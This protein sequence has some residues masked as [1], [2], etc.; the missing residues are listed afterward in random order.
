MPDNSILR[1]TRQPLRQ[2]LT[3][4]WSPTKGFTASYD[5]LGFGEDE[6]RALAAQYAE[7]GLETEFVN[8]HGV[9]TLRGMIAGNGGSNDGITDTVDVWE[10]ASQDEIVSSLKNPI[11]NTD[12]ANPIP[13]SYLDVIGRAIKDGS[14]IDEARLALNEDFS[15]TTY[16]NAATIFANEYA[17]R[18]YKRLQKDQTGFF[19]S[20][21]VLRHTTNVSNRWAANIADI[22]VNQIYVT[23]DLLS[24]VQSGALWNYPLPG[25]LAYKINA[26]S[27]ELIARY[28]TQDDHQWGWLKGA[29]SEMTGANNRVNIVTEYK[30]YQWSTDEYE[31]Y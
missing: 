24:E 26:L 2:K 19:D 22:G 10:I 7:L 4:K 28:G 1:G 15:P 6:M 13:T 8:E 16:P 25:R 17:E 27:S 14:T 29:S 21:F 5:W 18:L 23:A 9:F 30:F 12:G 31:V 20:R 3:E 11:Y